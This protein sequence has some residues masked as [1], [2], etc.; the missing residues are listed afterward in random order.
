MV[1]QDDI[2]LE[3]ILP[4]I[5]MWKKFRD[6]KDYILDGGQVYINSNYFMAELLRGTRGET[7][8]KVLSRNIPYAYRRIVKEAESSSGPSIFDVVLERRLE[9][10]PSNH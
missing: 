3:N 2:K 10:L 9:N 6:I 4:P 7:R 8:Y 5:E 1:K